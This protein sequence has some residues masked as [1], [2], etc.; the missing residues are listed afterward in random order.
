MEIKINKL[1]YKPSI[2]KIEEI[3]VYGR[4]YHS[5]TESPNLYVVETLEDISDIN[6]EIMFI[7]EDCE[8]TIKEFII[9]ELNGKWF[10]ECK[11]W[12]EKYIGI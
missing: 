10:I 3:N 5:I 8:Y 6:E 11:N 1:L 7:Y 9:D 2:I 4:L 12:E